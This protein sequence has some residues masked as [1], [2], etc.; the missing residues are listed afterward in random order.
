MDLR[1]KGTEKRVEGR[2]RE[3]RREGTMMRA[4]GRGGREEGG[5]TGR[6]KG[7]MRG[8]ETEEEEWMEGHPHP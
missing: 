5:R 4:K 1:G 2:S 3:R 8:K 6:E 7:V